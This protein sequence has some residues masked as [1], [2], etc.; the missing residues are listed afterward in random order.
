MRGPNSSFFV[1]GFQSGELNIYYQIVLLLF[2]GRLTMAWAFLVVTYG[3]YINFIQFNSVEYWLV[4]NDV[5]IFIHV[6]AEL[7]NESVSLCIMK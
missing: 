2:V 5:F 6:N 7:T 3:D 1:S 4:F